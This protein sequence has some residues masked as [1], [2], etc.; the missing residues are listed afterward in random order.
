MH[1]SSTTPYDHSR[2]ALLVLLRRGHV[3]VA[4]LQHNRVGVVLLVLLVL[5]RHDCIRVALLRHDHAGVALLALLRRGR[6]PRGRAASL[7]PVSD[8]STT[9]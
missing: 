2:V 6:E 7:G 4:L 1:Q 5:L 3:E 8:W 9:A